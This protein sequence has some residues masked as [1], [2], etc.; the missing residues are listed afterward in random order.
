M[1]KKK[2]RKSKQRRNTIPVSSVR[3]D[4][5]QNR[6]ILSKGLR[7][8]KHRRRQLTRDT[9]A[10][11]NLFQQQPTRLSLVEDLRREQPFPSRHD[12]FKNIDGSVADTTYKPVPVKKKMSTILLLGVMSI[13]LLILIVLSFAGVDIHAEK[14]Y[15]LIKFW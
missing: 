15:S 12:N 4:N 14:Y 10:I 5:G 6:Y 8:D 7:S 2:S 9:I 1:A 3:S 11:T 13:V